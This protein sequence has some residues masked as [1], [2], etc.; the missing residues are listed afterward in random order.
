MTLTTCASSGAVARRVV[1][2][3]PAMSWG[4]FPDWLKNGQGQLAHLHQ[5]KSAPVAMVSCIVGADARPKHDR[6][7]RVSWL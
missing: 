3:L 7:N 5:L 4:I 2:E 6:A 1:L